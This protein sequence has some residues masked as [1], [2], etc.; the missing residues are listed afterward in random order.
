MK[1]K[2]RIKELRQKNN[3][4]LKE[5]SQQLKNTGF[6]ISPDALGK[7]ERAEREP[8]L[9]TWK[10]LAD[11][12]DVPVS[13]LQGFNLME[14]SYNG[15][16]KVHEIGMEITNMLEK[17]GMD[18]RECKMLMSE[19]KM[20]FDNYNGTYVGFDKKGYSYEL[21]QK[22]YDY[23]ERAKASLTQQ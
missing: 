10:K 1:M 2:N 5:L 15:A 16:V 14:S 7:Y 9:E 19:I 18:S 21:T 12:F 6:N 20:A 13:Y 4:T 11:F 8:K 23:L 17:Y 22:E 3:L